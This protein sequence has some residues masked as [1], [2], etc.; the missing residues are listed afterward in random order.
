MKDFGFIV[1][2]GVTV[3]FRAK[4]RISEEQTQGTIPLITSDCLSHGFNSEKVSY[5]NPK[6]NEKLQN[7]WY[8]LFRRICPKE[9]QG[10]MTVA[11]Y[12]PAFFNE[13]FI[14]IELSLLF[15]PCQTKEDCEMIKDFLEGVACQA[16]NHSIQSGN[17]LSAKTIS[18]YPFE[19][20][21]LTL[22]HINSNRSMAT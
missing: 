15:I 13:D 22:K 2:T 8:V 7:Q 5:L 14:S 12:D 1:R 18:E 3:K 16:F 10:Q 20:H 19:K 17:D 9:N 6:K 4:D 21:N 11:I